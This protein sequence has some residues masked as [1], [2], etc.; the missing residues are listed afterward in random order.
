MVRNRRRVREFTI[1]NMEIKITTYTDNE[2]VYEDKHFGEFS[3]EISSEKIVYNDKNE[4]KIKIF[5]DKIKESVSILVSMEKKSRNNL[6][7]YEIVYNIFFDRNEKQQNKLKIL[8]KK[9]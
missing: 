2:K 7:M 9:N 4:K 5:I 1:D 6:V 3:E 8:I